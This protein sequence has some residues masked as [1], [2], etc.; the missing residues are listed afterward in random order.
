M[1]WQLTLA[2]LWMRLGVKP[3]LGHMSQVRLA[4]GLLDRVAPK[5]FR[6]PPLSLYRWQDLRPDLPALWISNR[7]GSHPP[8]PGKVVLYFHGGGFIAGSPLTHR[9]MLARLSRM[10]Q[11]EV[12]APRY[13]LAPEYPF[14]AAFDDALAAFEALVARG[15]APEDIILGGDSAGGAL[16]LALLAQLTSV[17]QTPR[18]LFAF[19]P[20]AD[21]TFSGAS[22][23]D[24]V[25]AD[26]CLPARRAGLLADWVL[27]GQDAN[28]P[29][30]SPLFADFQAPP[31]VLLQ[32]GSTE[33]LRDDSRR[34]AARLEQAGG[35]VT[36]DEWCGC[37]HVWQLMDGLV[38]EAR[39]ALHRTAGFV[40]HQFGKLSA[41]R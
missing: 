23:R 31:P 4:R 7:P 14:P 28:D 22:F 10:T 2:N 16:A 13:R 39:A 9:H 33:I 37:P 25:A 11:V 35:E 40:T 15:Y 24:N 41:S 19:S 32:V 34:I 29:R 5:V 20:L 12:V 6:A 30:I 18:A 21:M 26:P 1:S 36:C 38:P 27:A 3:V 17:G 8:L